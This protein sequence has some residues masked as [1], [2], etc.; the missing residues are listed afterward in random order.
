MRSKRT[1]RLWLFINTP[2]WECETTSI[3]NLAMCAAGIA[4]ALLSS[5]AIAAQ[6]D[7]TRRVPPY[8]P[9]PP[10]RAI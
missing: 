2:D 4:V 1:G 10:G 3:C 9:Y 8:N 6:N 7:G 5:G